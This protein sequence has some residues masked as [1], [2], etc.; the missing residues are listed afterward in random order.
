M[1]KPPIEQVTSNSNG[2]RAQAAALP[3]SCLVMRMP[4]SG[5]LLPLG[6]RVPPAE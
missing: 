1:V 4:V 5:S 3:V 6:S 2:P